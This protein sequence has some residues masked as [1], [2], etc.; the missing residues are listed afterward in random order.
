MYNED[1]CRNDKPVPKALRKWLELNGTKA[2]HLALVSDAFK[3]SAS[4]AASCRHSATSADRSLSAV[5]FERFAAFS[6]IVTDKY[7]RSRFACQTM[8]S[9]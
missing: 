8:T 6:A 9:T 3:L 7:L 4:P 5:A 1:L 2:R